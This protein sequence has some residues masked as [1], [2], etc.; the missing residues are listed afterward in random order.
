[1]RLYRVTTSIA[2][3]DEETREYFP[4]IEA[5]RA[6][7]LEMRGCIGD[8]TGD[9]WDVYAH[10]VRLDVP[11]EVSPA[12]ALALLN[13]SDAVLK[14]TGPCLMA[15]RCKHCD[16]PIEDDENPNAFAV[17]K[18]PLT[19]ACAECSAEMDNG[20]DGEGGEDE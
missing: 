16:E 8:D 3:V 20:N 14:Q 10:E 9:A 15:N 17:D 2:G 19:V 13:E 1:M 18:G 11:P 12:L 7:V 6:A 4:T 5:A